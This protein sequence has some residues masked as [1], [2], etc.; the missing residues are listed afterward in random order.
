[1]QSA[2]GSSFPSQAL[3]KFTAGTAALICVT[4]TRD[5]AR[6]R[7]RSRFPDLIRNYQFLK[8]RF[9]ERDGLLGQ[10]LV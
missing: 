1:M 3:Q 5:L 10:A 4:R 7:Q 8:K 9:L 2:F 6:A